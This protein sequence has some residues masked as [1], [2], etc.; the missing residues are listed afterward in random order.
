M[1][2]AKKVCKSKKNKI[3]WG[4]F[5]IIGAVVAYLI[6]FV[7]TFFAQSIKAT[8]IVYGELEVAETVYGYITRNEQ[9]V[10]CD[11]NGELYPVMNEGERV[12]KA[13]AVAVVENN[14]SE[15]ISNK[16]KEL[17]RKM[18]SFSSPSVFNND[19][20]LIDTEVNSILNSLMTSNYNE[21]FSSLKNI[22]DNIE[23]KLNKKSS[24]IGE[25][26]AK[27]SAEREYYEEIKK[28]ESQL[29]Y[30]RQELVAPIAGTVAYK[31]DGYENVFSSKSISDYE[32]E[33]LEELDVPTGELVGSIKENSFKIVDNIEGYVTVISSS[34]RAKNAIVDKKI[35][36]RFPEIS[37]E[38]IT[39]K[40]EF[41]TME[42]DKAIIT[43]RINRGIEELI[44]YRK[45]KV[46]M[47]WENETG[48]KVPTKSIKNEN[49][50]SKIFVINGN[51][52]LEKEIN[53]LAESN[54]TA[55]IEASGDSKLFLYDSIA[56]DAGKVNSNKI[57]ISNN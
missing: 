14:N 1:E 54:G 24:I 55:I 50:K 25:N 34:D 19:I 57:I 5:V 23:N 3:K 46:D 7:Y 20:M 4:R 29:T 36:L 12:S 41:V 26:S 35:K 16:I 47:I 2:T 44:N 37:Q 38:A 45:I 18:G 56:L 17:T 22:R 53:V 31:L 28:Y 39:G 6:M 30:A 10:T 13:Q 33:T 15:I 49:D 32:A 21:G 27:G 42:D 52:V 8:T 9:I 40:I 11:L 43:F 48:L 51:R